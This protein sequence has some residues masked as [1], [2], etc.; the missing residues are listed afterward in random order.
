[1]TQPGVFVP[2]TTGAEPEPTLAPPASVTT[3]AA[4]PPQ[5]DGSPGAAT[6]LDGP[7]GSNPG[8]QAS[9]AQPSSSSVDSSAAPANTAVAGTLRLSSV[10]WAVFAVVC[11]LML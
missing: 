7:N 5:T 4:S 8:T 6:T 1:M 11:V 9:A 3:S 10:F 2:A